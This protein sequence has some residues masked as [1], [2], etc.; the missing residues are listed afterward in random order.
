MCGR[1]G[2]F[3]ELDALAEQFGFAAGSV[4]NAYRP[5]WNIAPTAPVLT[6]RDGGDGRVARMMRWGLTPAQGSARRPLFNARAETVA[7]RPTFR[8]AFVARRCLAPANGFYEWRTG[9]GRGKSPVW[10]H[11]NDGGVAAFAG[12]WFATRDGA[13]YQESCVIITC[14]ANG[15]VA[16]VHGRMPVI[17]ERGQFDLW[18]AGDAEADALLGLLGVREWPEM[19]AH[20]VSTAVNGA[21][22]D[23]PGLVEPFAGNGVMRRLIP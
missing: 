3:A 19:A 17:L 21:A 6:V 12:I 18:L 1:F 15:L 16:P 20:G 5:R 8:S 11:R 13:G 14:A 9:P 7:E 23:G 22:N 10:F 4:G 2:L